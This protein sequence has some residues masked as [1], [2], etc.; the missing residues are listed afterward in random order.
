MRKAKHMLYI[1]SIDN[2]SGTMTDKVYFLETYSMLHILTDMKP[3]TKKL[4]ST[5][6]DSRPLVEIFC[7]VYTETLLLY[8]N[9]AKPT[10]L[11]T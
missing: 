9:G 11:D 7:F 1:A 4:Q 5:F 3:N 2:E 8:E 10:T 6:G